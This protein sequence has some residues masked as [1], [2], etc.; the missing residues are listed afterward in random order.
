MK[1]E[2]MSRRTINLKLLCALLFKVTIILGNFGLSYTSIA[3][4]MLNHQREAH[5]SAYARAGGQHEYQDKNASHTPWV[6]TAVEKWDC[7]VMNVCLV[8]IHLHL[9]L[10]LR[11]AQHACLVSWGRIL[12]QLVQDLVSDLLQEHTRRSLIQLHVSTVC[13]E[14]TQRWLVPLLDCTV[15]IVL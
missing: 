13:H 6:H 10:G 15:S 12:K 11:L 9:Q 4:S 1:V 3:K 8:N 5:Y 14:H 7:S 2:I